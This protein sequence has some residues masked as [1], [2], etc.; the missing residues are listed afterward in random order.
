VYLIQLF[1]LP[2]I[3]SFL[4]LL[5]WCIIAKITGF[6][7]TKQQIGHDVVSNMVNERKKLFQMAP[8][9]YG[10]STIDYRCENRKKVV[11]LR[12]DIGA[13]G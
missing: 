4:P 13:I 11:E 1:K 7:H 3:N 6:A 9:A 8:V 5:R 10:V 2:P 12:G